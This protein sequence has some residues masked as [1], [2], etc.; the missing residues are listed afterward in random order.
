MAVLS[1][2][3]VDLDTVTGLLTSPYAVLGSGL[4]AVAV[5]L[6]MAVRFDKQQ[7]RKI[8]EV[9]SEVCSI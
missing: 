5:I 7:Q 2:M 6:G 8:W 3:S 1:S 9:D 4:F